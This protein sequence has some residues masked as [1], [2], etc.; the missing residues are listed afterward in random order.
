MPEHTR[1][2]PASA[3]TRA[4]RGTSLQHLVRLREEVL[5]RRDVVEAELAGQ[6]RLLAAVARDLGSA[7]I[8][9]GCCADRKMPN[10]GVIEDTPG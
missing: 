10:R 6:P 1:I 8:A 3:A 2:S 5:A 4:S 9:G 7:A